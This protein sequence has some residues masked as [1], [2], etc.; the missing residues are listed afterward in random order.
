MPSLLATL[1]LLAAC[2]GG[3]SSPAPAPAP[4][5]APTPAPAPA[6]A[7]AGWTR[8]A[9]LPAGVA[10]FGLAAVNGKLIVA[11]GYDTSASS[12]LYDIAS[13]SWSTGPRLPRG[14]DNLAALSA[15]GKV[16]ALGGEASNALQVYDPAANTWSSGP[17]LPVPRF[18]AA[19]AELNGR[20]HLVGGWNLNNAASA[21]VD[22][23][24]AFD[25]TS[26][27]W[28]SQALAPL[29]PARNAAAAAVL[30]ARLCVA[31]GRG[32]GIRAT[33]QQPLDRLDCY[34]PASNSWAAEPA[35]PTAR[36]SLAA[37]VLG[38]KLYT[39][40][41]E[42]AART[43]SAAVERF[44]PATRSWTPLP[45]MPYAAHGLGAV[46]VGDAIYVLGG[47]TAASDAVGSESRQVWR[48]QP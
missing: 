10:K 9:D 7:P 13:N 39:F 41:G 40:G 1:C 47:F 16:Y 30:D 33:D 37:A 35:L 19:A 38:G 46:A 15:A 34:S 25:T 21:S 12:Y 2:G 26:Q 43:V 24:S 29:S 3:G 32:P 27:T 6:P 22:S 14:T 44:D 48:Y 42:T 8:L 20:L 36:G 17:A 18:A 28:L 45:A 23:H 11:G 31:G 5:P 4:A